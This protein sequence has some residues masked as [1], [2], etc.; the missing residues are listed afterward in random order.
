[1]E[2]SVLAA[3]IVQQR[4]EASVQ[5]VQGAIKDNLG[6]SVHVSTLSKV[7]EALKSKDL[8]AALFRGEERV[9]K[10]KR[11]KFNCNVEV[12]HVQ[13]LIPTLMD[14]PAGIAVKAEIEGHLNEGKSTKGGKA[15][16][17]AAE[18][19]NYEVKFK[20]LTPWY[21]SQVLPG[22]ALLAMAYAQSK[23]PNTFDQNCDP[24][25]IPL[26]FERCWESGGILV[27]NACVRG[28][29]KSHLQ[30]IGQSAWS[31]DRFLVQPIVHMPK[32]I[33]I[34]KHPIQTQQGGAGFGYYEAIL[35]GEELTM[36]FA[37][38]TVNFISPAMMERWLGRALRNPTR[39]MS[40]ARGSQTGH[41]KL[42]EIKH[43]LWSKLDE[44]ILAAEKKSGNGEAS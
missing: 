11:I 39:S 28:F 8:L 9:Y 10:M 20:L 38:P 1:V 24:T 5:D 21:G 31:V 30:S 44:D 3:F 26:L 27:H 18:W 41:A 2:L 17:L 32:K 34:A 43:T 36:K 33:I 7:L 15:R 13:K 25:M 16:N 14:D 29:I 19:A 12:A 37:A 40:P 35:P 42:V 23:Y 22:N 4:G 6:S